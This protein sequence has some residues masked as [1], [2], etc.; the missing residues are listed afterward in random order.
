MAYACHGSSC[1]FKGVF[2]EAEKAFLQAV[3]FCGKTGQK[4][5]EAWSTGWLGLMYLELGKYTKSLEYLQKTISIGAHQRH[6]PSWY[7]FNK[8]CLEM[9]K[10]LNKDRDINLTELPSKYCEK[11]KMKIIEGNIA[12]YIGEIFLNADDQH[13]AEAEDWIKKAIEADK[14]NGTFWS[15][16]GDY[17]VYSKLF[18]R[19]GDIPKVKKNLR[20]AIEIYK[21][22][23][24]DGWV[25]KYEN[26]LAGFG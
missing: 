2:A 10:A 18:K 14:R 7:N 3:N 24:A 25:S 12:R 15:L 19:K 17:A 11:N 4:N 23:G 21:E 6:F 13:L 1:Y 5:W 20:E 26:E 9:A 16:G 8:L 22:C